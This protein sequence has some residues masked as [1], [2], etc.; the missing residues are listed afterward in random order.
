MPQKSDEP[1]AVRVYTVCDEFR[2]LVVWNVLALGC[3]DDLLRL[4]SSYREIEECKPM[5]AEDCEPFIDIYWIKFHFLNNASL[6]DTKE[7]L[8]GRRRKVLARLKPGRS[9]GPTSHH[10]I[11]L[12][13]PS[14]AT[15][16]GSTRSS[17]GLEQSNAWGSV[18][19]QRARFAKQKL[20]EC[21]FLG[22]QLH[23]SYSPHFESLSDTKQKLEGRRREVLARLKCKSR[24]PTSHHPIA[25]SEPSLATTS[26][27]TGYASYQINSC[28]KSSSGLEYVSRQNNVVHISPNPISRISSD[29]IS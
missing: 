29:E 4:F 6:F 11:T 5:D 3:G 9:R 23:V 27:S 17:N 7:K 26:R 19:S 20:D 22:N 16:S 21:V 2:Y 18:R 10:L 13:E 24:G 14:L 1:V 8:E 12:S 28:Q 25:L 15:T